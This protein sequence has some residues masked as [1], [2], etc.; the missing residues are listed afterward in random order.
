[1]NHG[2]KSEE[3]AKWVWRS[4]RT[5]AEEAHWGLLMAGWLLDVGGEG[6]VLA[7]VKY[8]LE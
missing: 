5:P 2:A 7:Q 1:V 3:V 6:V 4:R 8:L